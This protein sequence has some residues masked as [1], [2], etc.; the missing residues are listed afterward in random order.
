MLLKSATSLAF[1]GACMTA[2]AIA[3]GAMAQ[4]ATTNGANGSNYQN[5]M[6]Q[7]ANPSSTYGSNYQ[8]PAQSPTNTDWSRGGYGSTS[9]NYQQPG[10]YQ[11]SMAPSSA[12]V[13]GDQLVTNGPQSTGVE[14]SGDWSAR[15]NV[16]QSRHYTRM[17]ETSPSF[18]HARMRKECGPIT[19]AQLH[20]SCVA[21][22][23]EY[24]PST[25]TGSSTAPTN[26]GNGSGY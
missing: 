2:L 16:I 4:S 17:L 24:A 23:S 11:G 20:S 7:P 14:R 1:A 6:A 12:G 10:S 19:D 25:M 18:R 8:N 26:Y 9:E 15:Q 22:F 5:Q 21:S 3:P 13:S